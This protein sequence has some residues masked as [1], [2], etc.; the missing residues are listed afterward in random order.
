MVSRRLFHPKRFEPE[1]DE[2]MQ[3]AS[4]IA[5]QECDLIHR[6]PL[7]NEGSLVKCSR[8]GAILIHRKVRSLERTLALTVSGLILFALANAFPL[9]ELRMEGNL[10]QTTLFK[11]VKALYL[12]GMW[13]LA[14]LV[15]FTTILAP[16]VQLSALFYLY[17]PLKFGRIPAFLPPVF[18]FVRALQPWSMMEVFMLAILVSIVKLADMARIIVG[19]SMY[20]FLVL[21]FVMAAIYAS[22]DSHLIWERWEERK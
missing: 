12:Q 21:I 10:Q 19:V 22:M 7:L 6:I 20:S 1:T 18:K 11:G 16:L 3:T 2:S 4:L 13:E 15:L 9:L 14:L 17:L 5:C 8:C